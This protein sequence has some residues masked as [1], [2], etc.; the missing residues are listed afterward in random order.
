MYRTT[1]EAVKQLPNKTLEFILY[2][3]RQ[4]TAK[5]MIHTIDVTNME[6]LKEESYQLIN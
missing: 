6:T 2:D 1:L 4:F 5:N 3:L